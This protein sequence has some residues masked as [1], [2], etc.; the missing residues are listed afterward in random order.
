MSI[1][2]LFT[3]NTYHGYFQELTCDILN[4]NSL[5]LNDLVVNNLTT[6][7]VINSNGIKFDQSGNILNDYKEI[8][9]NSQVFGAILGPIYDL[10]KLTKI[11]NLV[12]MSFNEQNTK[13]LTAN[14]KIYLGPNAIP[15]DFLPSSGT[16]IMG[17]YSYLYDP[18]GVSLTPFIGNIQ[19]DIST[20][21]ITIY[22]NANQQ[23]TNGGIFKFVYSSISWLV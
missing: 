8:S 13:S 12:T 14:D 16:T 5:E 6:N 20:G 4:I 1:Q 21:V 10:F 15:S 22:N 17:S 9:V 7:N 18:L 19:I 3:R 23:F 11:G 2:N